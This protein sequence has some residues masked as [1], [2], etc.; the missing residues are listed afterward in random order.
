MRKLKKGDDVIVISGKDK[1]KRGSIVTI[2]GTDR[3]IVQGVN[4]VKKHQKPNPASGNMGGIIDREMP[5][6]ISNIAIYNFA[7][8]KPDRVG[9]KI[10]DNNNKVRVYRSNSEVIES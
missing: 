10:D 7:L 1:G 2:V 6:H 9:F 4:S 8:K 3:V 5:M